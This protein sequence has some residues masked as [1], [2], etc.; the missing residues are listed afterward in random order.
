M[1]IGDPEVL[2]IHQHILM[3][4]DGGMWIW[5]KN[6]LGNSNLDIKF[7]V[8]MKVSATSPVNTCKWVQSDFFFA[9]LLQKK[10]FYWCNHYNTVHIWSLGKIYA[11]W[12]IQN[13]SILANIHLIYVFQLKSRMLWYADGLRSSRESRNQ[14]RDAPLPNTEPSWDSGS[15]PRRKNAVI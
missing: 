4:I 15:L 8:D 7:G 5:R 6:Y 10:V 13:P 12:N 11:S 9:W 14:R 1:C 3:D 2:A